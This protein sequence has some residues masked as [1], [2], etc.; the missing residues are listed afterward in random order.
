MS[1]H[2]FQARRAFTLI[3]VLIVVAI[4]GILMGLALVGI[5]AARNTI[6]S[7]AIAMEVQSLATAVDAYK[8]KYGTYPP[9]GY[10]RSAFEAHF[11]SVFQTFNRPSSHALYASVLGKTTESVMDPAEALCSV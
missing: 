5:N 1:R 9:D 6:V 11:R 2:T 3:E 4:M 10:S 7:G 8:T